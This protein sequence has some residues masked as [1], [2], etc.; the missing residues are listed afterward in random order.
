M[1]LATDEI[2]HAAMNE[3]SSATRSYLCKVPGFHKRGPEAARRGVYRDSEPGRSSADNQHVKL[4]VERTKFPGAVCHE[5]K[6]L[7][8]KDTTSCSHIGCVGEPDRLQK[9]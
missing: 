5:R 8:E 6:L 1:H 9:V 7:L 3:L 2:A 4:I